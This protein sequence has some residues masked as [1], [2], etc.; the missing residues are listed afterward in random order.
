MNRLSRLARIMYYTLVFST[1]ISIVDG[2]VTEPAANPAQTVEK[3]R[4]LVLPA[5]SDDTTGIQ[6]EVTETVASVA[7]S[8]GR[9]EIIDRNH[10]EDI[11]LEQDLSLLGL[12]DDSSAVS[13]G[14][15]A[16]ARE[17]MLVSVLNFGQQGVPEK[18]D[19]K[20]D[21]DDDK[22]G[23]WAW[24]IVAQIF[25]G[26]SDIPNPMKW[27]QETDPWSHN[28]QTQI[29]AQVKNID[30]ETS[31]TLNSF[32]VEASHTGG[33]AGKSRATAMK[34][35][36]RKIEAKLRA[37]YRLGTEVLAV[38]GNE[39]L[40][41]LGSELGLRR[42]MVFR[43]IQPDRT[44]TY[45]GRTIS[46]PGDAV[47]YARI[48]AIGEEAGRATVIRQW[49]NILPGYQATERIKPLVAG[50]VELLPA[51]GDGKNAVG[52]AGTLAAA[53]PIDISLGLGYALLQ[54]SGG[55]TNGGFN[56]S[57]SGGLR[58]SF[59][60]KSRL[61]MKAG[62]EVAFPMR[63]DDED[64]LVFAF[65][66]ALT[67][68]A[69][70]ELLATPHRDWILGLGYRLGVPT[71]LWFYTESDGDSDKTK[72]AVWN[73]GAPEINPTGLFVTIGARFITP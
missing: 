44:E 35:L 34:V 43:I 28:M 50:R 64:H 68:G 17:A 46:V 65:A 7:I 31:E 8:L 30:V 12:I 37:F 10:L 32:I 48:G 40:L 51:A 55:K 27:R 52:L 16:A 26:V 15:I 54:D 3:K 11:L 2:Q 62:L 66:P 71:D 22:G 24:L 56:L 61:L 14:K 63:N 6:L 72:Q 53:G 36:Q 70:L 5:Q 13:L 20:D 19:D 59:T 1:V 60:L 18:S 49:E 45:A 21:D 29:T 33:S 41:P 42:G 67:I 57:V 9:F 47:G 69:E 58:R 38:N 23:F 73:D 25:R 4:L 39:L